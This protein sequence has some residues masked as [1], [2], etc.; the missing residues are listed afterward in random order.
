MT[1]REAAVAA[2]R[3]PGRR[4]RWELW[5]RRRRPARQQQGGEDGD[6]GCEG[7]DG[8]GGVRTLPLP[9]RCCKG[10]GCPGPVGARR[11]HRQGE[12]PEDDLRCHRKAVSEQKKAP[13]WP[14]TRMLCAAVKMSAPRATRPNRSQPA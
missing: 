10:N 13:C 6:Q 5:C 11:I 4:A 2:D 8:T 14:R 1:R 3:A 12:Q 7:E 9:V